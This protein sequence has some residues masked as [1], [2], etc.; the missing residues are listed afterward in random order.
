MAFDLDIEE[1]KNMYIILDKKSANIK[2]KV[3]K[4]NLSLQSQKNLKKS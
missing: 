1:S 4:E 2:K 3:L